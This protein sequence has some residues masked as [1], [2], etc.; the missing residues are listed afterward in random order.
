MDAGG[1]LAIS[2]GLTNAE[3]GAMFPRSGGVYV[4]L[5]EAYG[6]MV[7]FL[8]GWAT[9]LVFF[10]GGN[11]AV[12]VGFAEYLSYFPRPCPSQ[13]IWSIV[14]TPWVRGLS[15]AQN[16][17]AVSIAALA[18]VNYVGVRTGSMVTGS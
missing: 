2:G 1:V 13:M 17:A 18:A 10:S 5:S 8:Y 9:L 12:A 14:P 6:P 11:A 4:Y 3:M 15:A 16:V 7:A